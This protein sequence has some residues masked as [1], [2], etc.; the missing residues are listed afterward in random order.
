MNVKRFSIEF[1]PHYCTLTI[2]GRTDEP[3]FF[4][5]RP[6]TEYPLD[7]QNLYVIW[8]DTW[9]YLLHGDQDPS[10]TLLSASRS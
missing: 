6:Y 9:P 7:F 2:L 4:S 3:C 5:T 10:L 1:G 8:W